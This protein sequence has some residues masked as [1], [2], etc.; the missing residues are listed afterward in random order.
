ML[1]M[2]CVV[3]LWADMFFIKSFDIV[4]SLLGLKPLLLI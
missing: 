2:V 1:Y 3:Y 4:L